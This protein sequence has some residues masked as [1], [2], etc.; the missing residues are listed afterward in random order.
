[1]RQKP[2]TSQQQK[3]EKSSFSK[4]SVRI[5]WEEEEEEEAEADDDALIRR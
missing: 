4:R 2:Q 1:M 3:L 5:M